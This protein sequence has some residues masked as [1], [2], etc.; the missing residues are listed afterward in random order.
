L[1]ITI[2]SLPGFDPLN[3]AM[4]EYLLFSF[5]NGRKAWSP[6]L[7][8]ENR[9]QAKSTIFWNVTPCSIVEVDLCFG[10]MYCLHLQRRRLSQA[11][12]HQE[13]NG[14]CREELRY[15]IND[16]CLKVNCSGR[17]LDFKKIN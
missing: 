8:R 12:G 13:E 14:V 3:R 2:K 9:L 11:S 7:R 6:V 5:L 17:Y 16:K 10:G 15:D 1:R 4:T